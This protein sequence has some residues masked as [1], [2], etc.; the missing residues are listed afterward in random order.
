MSD[1]GLG[2]I[3]AFLLDL[4]GVLYRGESA[5]PGAVEFIADLQRY[6]IPF[7]F[8]TNNSSRTPAQYVTRLELM[9]LYVH[10]Q[11]FLTSSLV[12]AAFLSEAAE[13]GT[14][15]YVIGEEGL[16]G[17]LTESGLRITG[18]HAEAR[19]VVVG[20][21][22]EVTW[23][24]LADATLAVRR[25]AVFVA[26]NPDRTLPTEEG[27]LPGAGALLAA[28]EAASGIAPIVIGKP[29]IAIFREALD[30]LHV[31]AEDA[32]MIGDRWDTDILGA[33]RAGLYA[34]AVES[35]VDDA[36]A[37]HQARPQPDRVFADLAAFHHAWRSDR[38]AAL[39]KGR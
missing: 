17:A 34:I 22:T 30:R 28:L 4:D 35:G 8:V 1:R 5:I 19:F 27:L 10:E 7:M 13:P 14:P 23:R 3:G 38:R 15:V 36:K 26:T 9:G 37:L 11:A 25:G 29:E 18:D 16:R 24:R 33:K 6:R 31:R 32:A 2:S 21:D 20:H 12:T 39:G